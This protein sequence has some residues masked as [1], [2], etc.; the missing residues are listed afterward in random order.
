MSVVITGEKKEREALKARRNLLF[1]RYLKAPQDTRL[2]LEIKLI[3]DQVAKFTE[4]IDRKR[5][6]NN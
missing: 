3:D 1:Q 5:A 6:S 4:Q 2:A